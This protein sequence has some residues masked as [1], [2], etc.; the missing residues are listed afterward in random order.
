MVE[1]G[2]N[3]HYAQKWRS[4]GNKCLDAGEGRG[5]STWRRIK[6]V[7][8]DGESDRKVLPS[9]VNNTFAMKPMQSEVGHGTNSYEHSNWIDMPWN[10][11][12]PTQNQFGSTRNDHCHKPALGFP[13]CLTVCGSANNACAV[14]GGIGNGDLCSTSCTNHPP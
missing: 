14:S 11:P 9:F 6:V 8:L 10:K 12:S 2:E 13:A 3:K 1:W 5:Q 4:W 7:E